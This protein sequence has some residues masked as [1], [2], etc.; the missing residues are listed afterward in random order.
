MCSVPH[1]VIY[2]VLR[3]SGNSPARVSFFLRFLPILSKGLEQVKLRNIV[4][5]GKY[6]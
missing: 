1:K 3:F 4:K 2:I 6:T 5:W